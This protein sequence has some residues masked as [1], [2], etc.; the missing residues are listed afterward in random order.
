MPRKPKD[1][2][3]RRTDLEIIQDA[4]GAGR[5]VPDGVIPVPLAIQKLLVGR[6]AGDIL[7]E[8]A[9]YCAHYLYNCII[10]KKLK[11]SWPKIDVAKYIIDQVEGKARIRAELTGAGGAPLSWQA[12]VILAAKAEAEELA[13]GIPG[14]P[15]SPVDGEV[16][17]GEVREVTEG[18]K[19][20]REVSG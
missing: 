19:D 4:V 13:R 14:A 1:K 2:G 15:P 11:P 17:D 7:K 18:Y 5:P 10:T 9:P 6:S 3:G 16:V 12:L 8:A 20:L